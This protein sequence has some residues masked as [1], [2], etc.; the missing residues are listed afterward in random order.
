MSSQW[1]RGARCGVDNCRSR[2]YRSVDGQRICQYG[3]VNDSH[4]DINDEEDDANA[5]VLTKRIKIPGSQ[6]APR[7]SQLSGSSSKRGKRAYGSEARSLYHKAFQAVLKAQVKY[8]IQEQNAPLILETVVKRLWVQYLA[9]R[10]INSQETDTDYSTGGALTNTTTGTESDSSKSIRSKRLPPFIHTLALCYLGCRYL[11]IPIYLGD[12]VVWTMTSRLP[13]MKGN[14]EIPKQI[15]M[16][17]PSH[18]ITLFE[19]RRPPIKA[20]LCLAVGSL[21]S[22]LSLSHL[23]MNYEPL[24]FEVV[25]ELVLPPSVY[26]GVSNC[27]KM[28]DVQFQLPIQEQKHLKIRH[29][30]EVKLVSILICVSKLYF[31]HSQLQGS[32]FNWDKWK[33]IMDTLDVSSDDT[34][35]FNTLLA[36]LLLSESS[37]QGIVDWDESKTERYLDWFS[38]RIMQPQIPPNDDLPVALRRLY[39]I[40]EMPEDNSTT[41][42]AVETNVIFT[43]LLQDDAHENLNVN[44]EDVKSI[45]RLLFDN[46]V[47]S[48]GITRAQLTQTVKFWETTVLSILCQP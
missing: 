42:N 39:A 30:P 15:R 3:H 44:A 6:T 25:T 46:I 14:V 33:Q 4:V 21:A 7:Q 36:S 24:L 10:L 48:F 19:P 32:K 2:Y 18:L 27:I 5:Y 45:E 28:C 31:L 43:D 34:R 40:F 47:V 22:M 37:K 12:F 16:R 13:Y 17:L 26:V 20:D 35:Q 38:K 29:F 11:K 9:D 41:A 1:I 8:L 23:T